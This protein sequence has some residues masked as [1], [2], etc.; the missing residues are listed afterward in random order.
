MTTTYNTDHYE[1][2]ARQAAKTIRKQKAVF[3]LYTRRLP[4]G[5]GFGVVAGMSRLMEALENF[6]YTSEFIEDIVEAGVVSAS[7][8]ETLRGRRFKG[9][10]TGLQDGDLY[11]PNTPILTVEGE[12]GDILVV[13]TLCLSILNH[14]SA[15]A[16]AAARMKIAAG[17]TPLIEAGARRTHEAAAEAA[18]IAAY[19]GGFDVSSNL[20]ALFMV[21]TAGT[22]MHAFVLAY[23]TEKEA[24]QAQIAEYGCATTF[25]VDTYDIR[26]GIATAIE[27]CAE[28]GGIPK[29][30]RIDSG[31][32]IEES[33]LAREQLDAAG[34]FDT[35]I[36]V[37][38]DM[39][40]YSITDLKEA[41]APVDM[42]Q[43]GTAL[44]TGSGFPAAGMV[45][46]LVAIQRNG[47]WF[48][49]EKK[50]LNKRSYG[51]HK[52]LVDNT[53]VHHQA[54]PLTGLGIREV[55]FDG[56]S[57]ISNTKENLE[58][59][60]KRLVENLNNLDAAFKRLD[61]E[62]PAVTFVSTEKETK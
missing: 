5:R 13:E 21:P 28:A 15:V 29:A 40:E 25:L 2:T 44:V 51:G 16:S 10:V 33:F 46:K 14:A 9:K 22:V 34:C 12:Y 50:S 19:I 35:N 8:G 62:P 60:R 49:V 4:G 45:F 6:R 58:L 52:I 48:S 17:D 59:S 32:L 18:T 26:E 30:I 7:E 31:D 20:A 37:S 24:F 54:D 47:A 27:A 23:E 55:L 11:F 1:L 38:G 56:K 41:G 3:D 42:F 57:L 36:I 39:D 61:A 53:T 43:V